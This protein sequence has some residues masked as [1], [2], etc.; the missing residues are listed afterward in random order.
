M[1]R[2]EGNPVTEAADLVRSGWRWFRSR[3]LP[4]QLTGWAAIAVVVAVV[5]L[6][7][8]QKPPN[9]NPYA[10]APDVGGGGS[11]GG[12]VVTNSGGPEGA[13]VQQQAG[14][15]HVEIGAGKV[16]AHFQA[17]TQSVTR[18]FN[19]T[20]N[21]RGRA[22]LNANQLISANCVNGN[23]VIKYVPDGP[24]AGRIIEAQGPIWEA[25]LKDPAWKSA[26]I[27]ALP[28]GPDIAGR[29]RRGGP[30]PGAGPPAVV[31]TCTRAQA[32]AVGV[33]GVQSGPRIQQLCSV[34]HT[35]NKGA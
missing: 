7:I 19:Q 31:I 10:Q 35:E 21:A 34:G 32:Q 16:G 29:G 4:L 24:G 1:R 13:D 27:A 30:P 12:Q 2:G 18:L 25:L 26:T 11:V 22:G 17:T 20:L 28:G 6:A 9:N 15:T 5:G 14:A 33:W 23:C 8:E 3:P